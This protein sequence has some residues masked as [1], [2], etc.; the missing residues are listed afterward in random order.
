MNNALLSSADVDLQYLLKL[1]RD[2]NKC[3]R[4]S[5][6]IDL[7]L[8]GTEEIF[9]DLIFFCYENDYLTREAGAAVLGSLKIRKKENLKQVIELLAVL[10]LHETSKRVRCSAISALG[11]RYVDSHCYRRHI[12][13][14][15][16]KTTQDADDSIRLSTAEAVSYVENNKAIPMI[17]KLLRDKDKEVRD[18]TAFFLQSSKLD[19][20]GIRDALVAMLN[21][22][23]EDARREAIYALAKLRDVRVTP[24]LQKEL[25]KQN[26]VL[27]MLE[28]AGD[29]GVAALLP[30]LRLIVRDFKGDG[31]EGE[32]IAKKQYERL[33]R[34]IY[35][36]RHKGRQH[37]Q[38]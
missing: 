23:Y 10:A 3:V 28:A 18:W 17:E 24:T 35:R 8:Y 32:K 38:K 15:L 22:E 12:L 11:L 4:D 36:Q 21:D 13:S 9:G 20:E 6:V 37:S 5:A 29:L 2:K 31:D 14:V 1:A 27:K 19:S 25:E 26:I 30:A 33:K 16:S 34:K 7:Q